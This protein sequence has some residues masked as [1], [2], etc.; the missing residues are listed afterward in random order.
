MLMNGYPDPTHCVY[1]PQ[2]TIWNYIRANNLPGEPANWATDPHGLREALQ[3][4]NTPPGPGSWVLTTN[5]VREQLMFNILYWM[6]QLHYGV[7]TLVY[8]SAHWVVIKGFQTDVAPV[9]GNPV[10]QSIT[11]RDPW[12]PN[13][14]ATTT[15]SGTVWYS[16]YWYGPVDAPGTWYNNY[17][18]VIEPP[19]ASQ[20]MVYAEEDCRIGDTVISPQQA[21][22]YADYWKKKLKLDKKDSAYSLLSDTS[23]KKV[24]PLTP[25]LV[26]E[27]LNP[28][29]GKNATV[30]CYYIVPYTLDKEAEREIVRFCILVNAFTGNFEEVTSYDEPIKYLK[31]EKALEAVAFKKERA[32]EEMANAEVDVIFTP[33]DYSYLRSKP[34]W[35]ISIN[36]EVLY[37][38]MAC[39]DQQMSMLEMA[40]SCVYEYP[41]YDPPDPIYGK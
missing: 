9:S 3:N 1:I 41:P 6:N 25:I 4:L 24:T 14:G 26:R 10:L 16:S 40:N 12:P 15:M 39:V 8:G 33:C 7:P 31:K 11:I 29:L 30:P 18:A 23:K 21:I 36:N 34:L 28:R 38:E 19:P 35:R 2:L 20:G 27:E 37:V 5:P 32:V 13:V 17:V 22:N